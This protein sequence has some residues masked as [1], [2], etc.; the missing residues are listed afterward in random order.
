VASCDCSTNQAKTKVIQVKA[1]D[2]HNSDAA[3]PSRCGDGS[4]RLVMP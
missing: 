1:R 3:T 4:Y 2:S